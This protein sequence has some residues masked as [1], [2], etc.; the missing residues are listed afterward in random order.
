MILLPEFLDRK[1]YL[2]WGKV[3][4]ISSIMKSKWDLL[5]ETL[6]AFTEISTACKESTKWCYLIPSIH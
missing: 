1:K 2:T 5:D 4:I 6:K 3:T